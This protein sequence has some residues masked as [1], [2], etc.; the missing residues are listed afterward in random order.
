MKIWLIGMMGTGKT[1]AGAL[2]ADR[3]GVDFLDTDQIVA[4]RANTSIERLWSDEG[5]DAFRD[6]ERVVV[7]DLAASNGIVA[8][9]GGVVLDRAN[10]ATMRRTGLVVWLE[11]SP[12]VLIERVGPDT[13]RPLLEAGDDQLTVLSRIFSER[14]DLYAKTAHHRIDTD[15]L[16]LAAISNRIE[17]LWKS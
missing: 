12:R 8:T 11:A 10:R 16:D 1:S 7:A 5:E 9:G 14:Q 15:P 3:L 4:E 6:L 17:D 2:A 13:G